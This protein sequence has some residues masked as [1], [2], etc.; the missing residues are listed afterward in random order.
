MGYSRDSFYR[1]QKLVRVAKMSCYNGMTTIESEYILFKDRAV[2]P[3][4]DLTLIG[5]DGAGAEA[6]VTTQSV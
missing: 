6:Y 4:P 5:L 1:F 2:D 3:D